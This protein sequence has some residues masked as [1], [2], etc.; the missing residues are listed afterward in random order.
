MPQMAFRTIDLG[1]RKRKQELHIDV[2]F[3]L[4]YNGYPSTWEEYGRLIKLAKATKQQLWSR[5]I[6]VM[7]GQWQRARTRNTNQP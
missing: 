5:F 3:I 1:P 7:P 4:E 2:K 6:D